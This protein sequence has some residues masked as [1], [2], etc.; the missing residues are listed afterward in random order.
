M[1]R[2]GHLV[3]RGNAEQ[4]YPVVFFS[5]HASFTNQVIKSVNQ[6]GFAQERF[7]LGVILDFNNRL[8][9]FPWIQDQVRF[10]CKFP[11]YRLARSG[12]SQSSLLSVPVFLLLPGNLFHLLIFKQ[13]RL[14]AV[15]QIVVMVSNCQAYPHAV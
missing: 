6:V 12:R 10:P 9:F 2:V 15:P 5:R 8:F 3:T 7:T 14:A 13:V 4:K 1:E 11:V